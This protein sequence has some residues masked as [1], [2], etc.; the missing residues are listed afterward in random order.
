MAGGSSKWR[1]QPWAFS[2]VM[3]F[4]VVLK[5]GS[6]LGGDGAG[7]NSGPRAFS[8]KP[9]AYNQEQR[10]TPSVIPTEKSVFKGACKLRWPFIW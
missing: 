10:S 2:N 4:F 6:A 1:R 7:R 9:L 3:N 5:G 8:P